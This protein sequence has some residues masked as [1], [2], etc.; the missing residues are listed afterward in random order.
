MAYRAE[1]PRRIYICRSL[2]YQLQRDSK[3]VGS[4]AISMSLDEQLQLI[5]GSGQVHGGW[6]ANTYPDVAGSGLS[7][8]EHYLR[9]GAEMGRN[10]RSGFDTRYY[11]ATYPDVAQSG[12]NPLAHYILF[13]MK[14]GRRTRADTGAGGSPEPIR[15]VRQKLLSFGLTSRAENELK[16]FAGEGETPAERLVAAHELALWNMRRKSAKGYEA[17]L[18]YIALAHQNGPDL[19]RKS[20]LLVMEL[21]C[22]LYLGRREEAAERFRQGGM[23]GRVSADVLLAWTNFFDQP[24]DRL[25]RM[26]LVLRRYALP[27]MALL[28]DDGRAAY[29]RLT[30][31]Q[32]LPAVSGTGMPKVTVLIAAYDCADTIGTALRALQEQ[33]WKNLEIIVLD[34]CSPD[35]TCAVVEG[36]AAGDPRIRLVRMAE[37]GG[38][39]I[40]RNEG[41][42]L[43]TGDFVT[44]H[45]ADDWAHPLRIETQAR[46]LI[47]N[48]AVMGCTTQQA[49]VNPDLGFTRWTG[50]GHFIITNTSSFMFRR[51]PMREKLGYWDT[52]RFSADNELVRRMKKVFGKQAVVDIKSGPLAFQRDSGSSIVA[53]DALGING[54]LFG[55][56][57]EYFD[58]QSQYHRTHEDLRYEKDPAKRRFPIPAI[59]RPDKHKLPAKRHFPVI[60]ASDF[61]MFGGSVASCLQEI[62]AAK[63]AGYRVGLFEMYRYDLGDRTRPDMLPEVRAE[64]DGDQVQILTYGEEVSCDL[65]VLR[66][67][68]ILQYRH[69]YLPTIDAAEIRVVINQPPMS[70][71]TKT[72]IRRYQFERCASNLRHYFG[73]DATWHPNGPMVREAILT[74]HGDEL[75]HITL[76][77]ENWDNIIHLPDW[78]RPAHTPGTGGKLRIGRHARDNFVKWPGTREDLLAIYPEATDIEVHILGGADTAEAMIG[79]MPANWVVH[80]FNKLPPREF[81][82]GLDVFIFFAHPDW[83]ESFPRNV[84]EAMAVGVPVILPDS[85]RPLFGDR[86]LY[87]TPQTAIDT[88]RQL[89]ADPAAYDAQ[90]KKASDYLEAHY[91]YAMHARRL[92]GLGVKHKANNTYE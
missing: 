13:G 28:P 82:A 25:L 59:M 74:H 22:L 37:N 86:A 32:P 4:M 43:A 27:E 3:Q 19:A 41:L 85:H 90:V 2:E 17:A 51:A 88:A 56:R 33:T 40:A 62:R 5:A 20:R 15:A 50:M 66:Y 53:D 10:P 57:K 1:G 12:L 89:C 63:A 69:R 9:L 72:G 87:A 65:L 8:A 54:F 21:L 78:R 35:N 71:Y 36:I 92:A 30:L 80:G 81:L 44:L 26:N 83:V 64:I 6:Y 77:P 7:A 11:C 48:E 49:R 23:D 24:E 45:D 67:P 42:D 29:D 38:A 47:D 46:F 55:A 60:I 91:S 16:H 79:H 75:K 84:L 76:S 18:E 70:D 14:E 73:K 58:A 68:P 34:D 61:R 39:Y 52:A 31:A